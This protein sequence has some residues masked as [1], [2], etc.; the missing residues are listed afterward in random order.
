MGHDLGTWSRACK[1]SSYIC[2]NY[3]N[4]ENQD[5]AIA[6]SSCRAD[7]VLPWLGIF[8]CLYQGHCTVWGY[9]NI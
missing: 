3:M 8:K 5:I 7:P 4:Y 2:S 9:L 1:S 6:L